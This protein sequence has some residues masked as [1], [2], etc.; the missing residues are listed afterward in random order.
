MFLPDN[1]WQW[2][3][4]GGRCGVCGDLWNGTQDNADNG[5]YDSGIIV[6]KYIDGHYINITFEVSSNF[7]GYVEFRLCPRNSTVH[8][9]EQSCFDRYPLWI[10]ESH[11]TRYYIGSR[12]GIY[13]I[14]IRL[15]SGVICKKCVLQ[16]KYKTGY[17]YNGDDNC[18]CLGC[19]K[20]EQYVN[21]ADIE[22][23]PMDGWSVET[24][25]ST[26][27]G[28]KDTTPITRA[29][30][31][32]TS[33][34]VADQI[35]NTTI[36]STDAFSGIKPK[37]QQ[38][39]DS[40][41]GIQTSTDSVKLI[42]SSFLN[43]TNVSSNISSIKSK[44]KPIRIRQTTS[45]L[46]KYVT[47]LTPPNI[48]PPSLTRT[49]P[50]TFFGGPQR[51]KTLSD[52]RK[53]ILGSELQS[54]AAVFLNPPPKGI[55]V[56]TITNTPL[57]R[58]P[59]RGGRFQVP[60]RSTVPN[61]HFPSVSNIL[62]RFY[63]TPFLFP[64]SNINLPPGCD[65][66]SD[67][68][69]CKARGIYNQSPGIS[70]WCEINCRASNCVPFMCECS[71]EDKMKNQTSKCHAIAEFHGVE[72]MDLWCVANCKVGYCPANTC[73]VEDCLRSNIEV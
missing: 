7:L 50:K 9:L 62:N 11:G 43:F 41:M 37:S 38:T 56:N 44:Q 71:C 57:V 25:T 48:S 64:G 8:T 18:K 5:K 16:W 31:S 26:P 68:F 42:D 27:A 6:R 24:T 4:H 34:R 12:G 45:T 20:Q 21:C 33:T 73:S 67:E 35:Q 36:S 65:V 55:G 66:F 60:S 30:D 22:I 72:G 70:K 17:R 59:V 32:I 46:Q 2:G 19:G 29:L 15:P 58:P 63:M 28:R 49:S 14:H 52:V 51:V 61:T 47:P 69:R 10:D 39:T 13:D 23:A 54:G 40:G 1:N 53:S 3:V